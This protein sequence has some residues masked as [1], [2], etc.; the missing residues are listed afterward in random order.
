MPTPI[1]C[2]SGFA[3]LPHVTQ[4]SARRIRLLLEIA[5]DATPV[6]GWIGSSHADGRGREFLGWTELAA[7]IENLT[8][9][10]ETEQ[11]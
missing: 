1:H 5:P 10:N 3:I 9:S 4:S 8:R 11:P 2:P 7:A 6:S